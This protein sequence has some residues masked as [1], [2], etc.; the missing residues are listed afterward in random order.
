MPS[1]SYSLTLFLKYRFCEIVDIVSK[2]KEIDPSLDQTLT[3]KN[4][5]F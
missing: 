1:F 4:R 3:N 2:I 5:Q